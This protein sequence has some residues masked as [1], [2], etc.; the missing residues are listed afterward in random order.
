MTQRHIVATEVVLGFVLVASLT[1]VAQDRSNLKVPN[2]LALSEFSGYEGWQTIAPSETE[3]SVKAILGND[4]MIKAYKEGFPAKAESVPDGAMIAKIEW[5][6][7]PNTV[8]PYAVQVPDSLKSL[9]FMLKDAKRFPDTAGWGWAQFAYDPA[10]NRFTP[11]GTGTACGYTCHTRVK[12][13][14]FVFTSYP[15]R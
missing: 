1:L 10:S 11:V 14:D 2:G 12:A 5:V 8:S 7:H 4:I 13:R 6:K 15:L 9:S 3:G